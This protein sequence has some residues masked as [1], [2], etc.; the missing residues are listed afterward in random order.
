MSNDKVLKSL[1]ASQNW[2]A[3][4]LTADD[5]HHTPESHSFT[6]DVWLWSNGADKGS[7]HF[8]TMPE[9]LGQTIKT[10]YGKTHASRNGLIRVEAQI[11]TTS[12]KTS[13]LWHNPTNSYLVALKA[14]VRKKEDIIV[15]EALT[16]SFK[17]MPLGQ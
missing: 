7:W 13:L 1:K 10:T 2:A 9:D 15:G 3:P 16:L 8:V 12:W 14:A 4:D 5:T 6:A 17:V 11:G